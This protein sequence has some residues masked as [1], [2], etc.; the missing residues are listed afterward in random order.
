G[1]TTGEVAQTINIGNNATGTNTVVLGSTSSTSSTTIQGGS[2]DILLSAANTAI[3]TSAVAANGVLTVGTDTQVATG[4]IYFG[5]DTNL[6]RVSAGYLKTDTALTVGGVNGLLLL[7]NTTA[8]TGGIRFGSSQDT[9][10]YRSAADTLKTDDALMVN[11]SGGLQLGTNNLRMGGVGGVNEAVI[12]ANS[13]GEITITPGSGIARVNILGFDLE[14]GGVLRGFGINLDFD[15]YNANTRSIQLHNSSLGYTANVTMDGKLQFGDA[16]LSVIDTNLYRNVDGATIGLRTNSRLQ[17]DGNIYA[18]GF[19]GSVIG[20]Y[21]QGSTTQYDTFTKIHTDNNNMGVNIN[22]VNAGSQATA[23]KL[24]TDGSALFKNA[25]NSTTAFQIQNTIGSNVLV[26]DTTA[27]NSLITNGSTEGTDITAWAS[28]QNATV[29]RDST[30]AYIGNYSIKTVLGGTPAAN[31]GVKY[32]P[33]PALSAVTYALSF[34]IKQ[35]AGTAF[36]TNLSVGWNNGTSDTNCT[37]DPTLTVQPV[38]TTGW[39][40]YSCTFTG[41]ASGHIY[42]KQADT[43][44][45][46]RTFFIDALQLEQASTASAFKESGVTINGVINSPTVFKN[47]ND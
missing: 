14:P 36:G 19:N 37:L 3:G 29:T 16:D 6:Y 8:N 17:A 33:S 46:A 45:S 38:P 25:T 10:L 26:A 21:T 44:G 34:Y 7:D 9:N 39:A 30:Q 41:S 1:N 13:N 12:G 5:T 47:T 18:S 20:F 40:R 4:G 28:K 35:T 27:L 2:G 11:N 31:D 24:N 15:A 42:W 23:L 32:T 43:P 22:V